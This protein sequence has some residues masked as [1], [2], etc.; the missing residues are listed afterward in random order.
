MPILLIVAISLHLLAS[1][2]WA[3]TTFGL[4]R[5]GG[6]GAAALFRPQM[7]AAT[8]TVLAGAYLWS[9]LH[10]GAEGMPEH[11]LGLGALCAIAAAGVQ[12]AMVGP[13]VRGLKGGTMTE[14]QARARF[15]RAHRIATLLLAITAICMG[16][17]RFV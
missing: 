15:A 16:A 14:E 17:Q 8:L 11:I 4:A 7:G 10:T 5:S 3:G 9:Q 13:A 6:A 12:G 1:I 2:F